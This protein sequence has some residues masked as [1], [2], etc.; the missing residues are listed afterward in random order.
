MHMGNHSMATQ[1]FAMHAPFGIQAFQR[2]RAQ[3]FV[4]NIF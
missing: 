2:N 1:V 3:M 4:V